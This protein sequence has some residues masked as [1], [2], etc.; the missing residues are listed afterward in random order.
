MGPSIMYW[1]ISGFIVLVS[2][3]H[4]FAEY[5]R[6]FWTVQQVHYARAKL[7]TKYVAVEQI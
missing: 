1:V 4:I 7:R 2:G 3:S 6:S 5:G